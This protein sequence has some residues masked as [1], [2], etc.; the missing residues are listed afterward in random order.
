MAAEGGLR[1]ASEG[2]RGRRCCRGVLGGEQRGEMLSVGWT[3]DED[4]C[5]MHRFVHTET[6]RGPPVLWSRG[7]GLE[8]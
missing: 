4:P 7:S 2:L 1:N 3:L 5:K 6:R 8:E